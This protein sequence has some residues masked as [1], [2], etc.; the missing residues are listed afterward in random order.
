MDE[1]QCLQ[2]EIL[3]LKQQI[4]FLENMVRVKLEKIEDEKNVTSSNSELKECNREKDNIK[5]NNDLKIKFN[6]LMQYK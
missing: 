1:I 5:N 6:P 3:K 4:K 2:F